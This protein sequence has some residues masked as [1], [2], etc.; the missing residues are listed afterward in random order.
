MEYDKKDVP[1]FKE[2][3]CKK[4]CILH[5]KCIEDGQNDH[6]FLMCPHYF[7]WKLKI[8]YSYIQ[9]DVQKESKK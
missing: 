2:Q 5:G 6:W 4:T 3:V 9:E 7:Y 1:A 8:P